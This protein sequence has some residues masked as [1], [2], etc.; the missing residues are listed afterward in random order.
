MPVALL[1]ADAG[2][3]W[4]WSLIGL[5]S[6]PALVLLNAFFVSAE[7][8]LVAVRRTRIEELVNDGV[9]GASAAESA[10]HHL[11]RSIA[12]TQLG[13]TLASIG[14]GFVGEP[15]LAY[16]FAPLFTALPA[17]G[18]LPPRTVQRSLRLS[19]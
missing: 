16:L 14:L 4:V 19:C 13:I 2:G 6:I 1:A 9:A 12:A 18:A 7:F 11:D 17:T 8:A 15:A 10:V 5:L 3:S